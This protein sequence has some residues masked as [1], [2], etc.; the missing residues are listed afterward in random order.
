M[1]RLVRGVLV[2]GLLGGAL[3]VAA[4]G[5]AADGAP[6]TIAKDSDSAVGKAC[7]EGGIPAAK[8]AMKD[9]V[10]K[11]KAGGVKF[12]CDD[13]HSDD[14]AYKLTDDSKEKFKKMLAAIEPGAA[15]SPAAAPAPKK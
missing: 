10:K 6:C 12:D 8:K 11:A 1:S 7:K 15:K 4:P 13:C 2:A 9:M 14:T 3:A 5:F